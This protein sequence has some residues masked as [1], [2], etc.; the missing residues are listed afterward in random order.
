MKQHWN[1]VEFQNLLRCSR[2]SNAL[3]R[4]PGSDL[5]R[6]STHQ[7]QK[8]V[9]WEYSDFDSGQGD[10]GA[11]AF[12]IRSLGHVR[13]RR[14]LRCKL[15]PEIAQPRQSS[16]VLG[17]R[18]LHEPTCVDDTTSLKY[19]RYVHFA[20][21]TAGKIRRSSAHHRN[22]KFRA[23]QIVSRALRGTHCPLA[24]VRNNRSLNCLFRVQGSGWRNAPTSNGFKRKLSKL[25]R[26]FG[27]RCRKHT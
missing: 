4:R 24:L 23:L 3:P 22:W 9:I 16:G 17:Q 11:D 15:F 1:R 6:S 8:H 7:R 10:P 21:F 12:K 25:L 5:E 26:W 14:F 20:I 27:R 19:Q 18:K 13:V 2:L